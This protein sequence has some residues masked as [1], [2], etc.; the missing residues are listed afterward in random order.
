MNPLLNMLSTSNPMIS[1]FMEFMHNFKGD[2]KTE[3]D[4]L[5]KSGKVT[6]AQYDDALAKA[7]QLE[8]MIRK[9]IR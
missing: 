8:P 5:I 6:Q 1:Q 3:I 9:M 4:N 2:P 7:K